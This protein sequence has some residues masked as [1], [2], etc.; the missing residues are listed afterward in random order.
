[1]GTLREDLESTSAS[2]VESAPVETAPEPVADATPA[3]EPVEASTTTPDAPRP[4]GRD[5]KGRFAPKATAGDSPGQAAPTKASPTPE[6]AAS[7][8]QPPAPAQP[9]QTE[10]PKP[11]EPDIT[12]APGSWR[13]AARKDWAQTPPSVKAESHRRELEMQQLVSRTAP[14]RQLAGELRQVL[15]PLAPELQRRGISPQRLIADYVQFDKAL[16]SGDPATQAQAL[17]AAAKGYG[18]PI[19]AL[20]DAWEGKG[21]PQQRQPSVEEIREQ[22]KS[23]MRQEWQQNQ[24]QME[25]RNHTQKVA[26]FSKSVDPVLFND[27]VRHDMAALI[28]AAAARNVEL[29]LQDAYD[30]AVRANP[31]AWAIV[32]QREAAKRAATELPATRRAEAAASSLKSRPASPVG[33]SSTGNSL[34]ADLEEEAAKYAGRT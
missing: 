30:R 3:P 21:R 24:Q 2:I 9:T 31:E 32:Q 18:V 25:Y 7:S 11:G 23:E 1:M 14:D 33:K 29:S 8:T 26:E 17:I 19:E 4:D 20:A 16:S 28:E 5:E 34:R 27:D 22:L 12:H 15:A 6:G 13:L 10:P